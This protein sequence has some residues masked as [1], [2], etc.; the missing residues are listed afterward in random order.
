MMNRGWSRTNASRT[1]LTSV[2]SKSARVS[3]RTFQSRGAARTMCEPI[4]P[5]APVTHANGGILVDQTLREIAV[6]IDAPVA[7]EW[8][9]RA[10]D[11]DFAEI[12]RHEEV[13]FF[14]HA[15]LGDDLPGRARDETLPPELDAVTAGGT[16]QTDAVCDRYVTAV[17]DAV[18]ALDQF[19][20]AVL[21]L[22]V[23]LLLA[24][25]P[26]DGGRIK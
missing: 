13:L 8:P 17:R 3:A 2:N 16:F 26:A 11:V 6:G 10:R 22:A 5:P 7:E 18:T 12:E 23:F 21:V 15:G 24:R 20:R 4:S 9:V 1:A 19:P 14:L 25:V